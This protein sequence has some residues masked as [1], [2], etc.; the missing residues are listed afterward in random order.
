MPFRT[1]TPLASLPDF[2]NP[3]FPSW[4][5]ANLKAQEYNAWDCVRTFEIAEAQL[6]FLKSLNVET[7]NSFQQ[8]LFFPALQAMYRG[9][10][11]DTSRR[12]EFTLAVMEAIASREQWLI[13]VIGRPVNIGSAPQMQ[14]LFY[15]DLGQK[16]RKSRATK[17]KASTPTTNDEA[18]SDIATKE[19]L[20]KPLV[21][22]I[23]ELRSLRVFLSTFLLAKLDSDNRMRCSYNP[24]GT[25]TYRLSSRQNAFGSGLNLQ[26]IPLGGTS[27]GLT[28]P[29]V[30]ELYIPDP[31]YTFFD[32]DLS[33][34]DLRIVVAESDEDEMRKMLN[35]GLDPYTE[36]A[37][38]FYHDPS[39]TKKDPR[40][41]T[42]KAF[43]HGTHYLGTAK[44][45]A[46]RL[47]LLVHE[48]EK[49][50]RW[51]FSRF[52]RIKKWQDDLKDQI[53]K[54]R[55]VQNIF[56]YRMYLLGRIEGTVMN[57]AAAWIPQSTVGL[58]INRGWLN[59]YNNLPEVQVLLQVHD[60]LAG[61]VRTADKARLLPE[62]VKA[63]EIPLPYPIPMTIPVGIKSS[64]VSWGKCG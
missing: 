54:R 33:S 38:E 23:Q 31:G 12:S 64:E 53:L 21:T 58:L 28:L 25:T 18:L 19:P 11:I 61:Q 4:D 20:L 27:N 52:P 37:K 42:F 17:H 13:D 44:G 9:L 55:Y 48:A 45:L 49:T 16:V 26:N 24:A 1:F 57:E 10:R 36:V 46:E 7:P 59:I 43:C 30:R 2:S 6:P 51:Y 29:N 8:A 3:E 50:Q 14:F 56:G 39:M 60:S 40:R 5:A 62:I 34:A 35:A 22:V 63:V 41:Q 32:I 47:G 15:E